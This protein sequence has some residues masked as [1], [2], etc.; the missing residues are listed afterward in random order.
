MRLSSALLNAN[1]GAG[2]M[3]YSSGVTAISVA[4]FTFLKAGDHIVREV[5]ERVKLALCYR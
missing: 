1:T 2:T 4:M 3:V 5:F